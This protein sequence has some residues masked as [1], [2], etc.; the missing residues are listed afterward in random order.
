[1]LEADR[2]AWVAYY[3]AMRERTEDLLASSD[4][5]DATSLRA[6]NEHLH[7]IER[8]LSRVRVI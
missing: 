3:E 7:S 8:R 1:M 2:A 5:W 4:H 6:I